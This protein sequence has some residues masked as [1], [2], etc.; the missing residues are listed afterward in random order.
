MT[1]YFSL[2]QKN[3][4]TI[5]NY[6]TMEHQIH[7]QPHHPKQH[8]SSNNT[9]HQR[10]KCLLRFNNYNA[11]IPLNLKSPLNT[12]TLQAL[13]PCNTKC[14][15]TILT[16]ENKGR[17]NQSNSKKFRQRGIRKR[18]KI[19]TPPYHLLPSQGQQPN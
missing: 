5:P 4:T 9:N 7:L 1:Q 19:S 10:N 15:I 14:R 16:T 6:C 3:A 17:S 18:Y 11:P 8:T 13:V 2:L 12:N